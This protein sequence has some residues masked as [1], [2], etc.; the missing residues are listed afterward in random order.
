MGEGC[1]MSENYVPLL[2][3]PYSVPHYIPPSHEFPLYMSESRRPWKIPPFPTTVD[4]PPTTMYAVTLQNVNLITAFTVRMD[5]CADA[6][7]AKA[8]PNPIL[9]RARERVGGCRDMKGWWN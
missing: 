2:L 6:D 4:N 3:L 5:L 8:N 9:Q 1:K 7:D